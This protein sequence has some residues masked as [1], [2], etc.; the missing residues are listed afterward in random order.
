MII[1]LTKGFATEI[2]NADFTPDIANATWYALVDKRSTT[3]TQYAF[4]MGVSDAGQPCMV[5]LH[6]LIMQAPKG[7][8]VDHIDRNGLNNKRSNLR[9]CTK[10]QNRAN[11]KPWKPAASGYR[12]V[13]WSG[14]KWFAAISQNGHKIKSLGQFESKELAARAYD[15]AAWER[16]GEFASLNFPR[17]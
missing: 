11:G 3:R 15:A 16:W 7:M 8:L 17:V 1:Q 6:R 12:G 5:L 4:R 14:R 2:D 13:Y 9:L 10:K